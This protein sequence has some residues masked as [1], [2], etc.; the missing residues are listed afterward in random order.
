M[1]A[2][3]AME[4]EQKK[5]RESANRQKNAEASNE[6]MVV[7]GNITTNF[8]YFIFIISTISIIA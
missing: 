7:S 5:K 2:E 8:M 4:L 6:N 3:N 1:K